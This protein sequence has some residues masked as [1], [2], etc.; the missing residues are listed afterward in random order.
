MSTPSRVWWL[1]FGREPERDR[2]LPQLLADARVRRVLDQLAR[3]GCARRARRSPPPP[4]RSRRR[5][6]GRTSPARRPAARSSRRRPWGARTAAP[7]APDRPRSA[8]RPTMKSVW[9]PKPEWI[10]AP[11]REALACPNRSTCSAVLMRRHR[12]VAPRSAPGR[13]SSRCAASAPAGCGA[14]TCTARGEPNTNDAVSGA[15]G[16]SAPARSRSST[17]SENI[18]VQIREPAALRQPGQGGVRAPAP[19][20]SCRVGAV[21]RPAPP[22][23]SPIRRAASSGS[24]GAGA[25]SSGSSTSRQAI[26]GRRGEHRV[27]VRPRH[28]RVHLRDD[29]AA[30]RAAR[31]DR[32]RQHV[33]LG[34]QRR[35]A[36]ARAATVTH[37]DVGW[38]RG[39]EQRRHQRQP[40]GQVGQ[41]RAARACR[42]RRTASR[43]RPRSRR[44]HRAGR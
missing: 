5:C 24:A 13:W 12:P 36:V 15:S 6:A 2:L 34:P 42:G 37:D 14:P 39:R 38:R 29:Q 22:T 40:G 10:R 3:L 7:S 1:R 43:A 18:S 26:H 32:G 21:A 16:S 41:R 8:G 17:P 27:A 11:M 31:L 25:S 9:P 28:L 35:P 4:A 19:M 23:S 33:D 20:P 44:A 30:A